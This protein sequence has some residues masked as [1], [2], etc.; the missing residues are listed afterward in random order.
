MSRKKFIVFDEEGRI[1]RAGF[2]A[3]PENAVIMPSDES[4]YDLSRLFVDGENGLTA[5]PE[6]S[7]PTLYGDSLS[8]PS[9][10]EGTLLQVIDKM[11]GDV[12][13]ETVTDASLT[14]HVLT[15]PDPGQYVVIV[16]PPFPWLP[17]QT[18]FEK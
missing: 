7:A 3:P 16:E 4:V 9:G 15:L 5:R 8:V 2:G 13:W 14:A 10:P 17:V 6:V 12:M 18:E 1:E 11:S